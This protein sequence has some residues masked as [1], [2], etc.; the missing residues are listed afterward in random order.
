MAPD[1]R[2]KQACRDFITGRVAGP[3]R[4]DLLLDGRDQSDLFRKVLAEC[5]FRKTTVDAVKVAPGQRVPAFVL[6]EHEAYFGWIFWEKFTG[7]K[8]R[9]LWGSVVR[10]AKGDWL[11]QIPA[12]KHISVYANSSRR[13]S[14][15]MEK[16][17]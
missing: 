11:I 16:P 2:I 17:V 6:Q 4:L 14:M 3:S 10:N 5:G 9:K 13:L 1:E 12:G 8:M 15:D 7:V